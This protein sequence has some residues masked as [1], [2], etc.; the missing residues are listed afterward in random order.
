[1]IAW[2]RWYLIFGVSFGLVASG[3][4]IIAGLIA[5]PIREAFGWGQ[6]AAGLGSLLGYG[7]GMPALAMLLT[8][9]FFYVGVPLT[10]AEFIAIGLFSDFANTP[11]MALWGMA[12]AILVIPAWHWGPSIARSLYLRES[13]RGEQQPVV[14]Q[15]L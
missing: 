14:D 12:L 10:F 9:G 1:M 8:C 13:W 7:L 4:W 11:A 6:F 3:F 2:L 15:T 5:L